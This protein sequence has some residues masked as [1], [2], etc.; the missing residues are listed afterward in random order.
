MLLLSD[1]LFLATAL[2]YVIASG[3]FLAY[4]AGSTNKQT[5]RFGPWILALGVVLH[6]LG[7]LKGAE[8]A[9]REATALAPDRLEASLDLGLLLCGDAGRPK[10]GIEMLEHF[11]QGGGRAP[12]AHAF[13]SSLGACRAL[14]KQG[15]P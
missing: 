3:I 14:A 7:D 11:H 13:E 2:T 9:L 15:A 5:S 4:L 12:D 10:E 1:A 6:A 8:E